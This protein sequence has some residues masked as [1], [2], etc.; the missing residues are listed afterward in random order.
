MANLIATSVWWHEEIFHYITPRI[1]IAPGSYP[2][3]NLRPLSD[4]ALLISCGCLQVRL[5]G[6]TRSASRPQYYCTLEFA[7][8]SL[9]QIRPCHFTL[10]TLIAMYS[11]T[12]LSWAHRGLGIPYFSWLC[13]NCNHKEGVVFSSIGTVT[14]AYMRGE[15]LNETNLRGGKD[16]LAVLNLLP[17]DGSFMLILTM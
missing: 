3:E 15:P 10:W 7:F 17:K 12:T 8:C 13:M 11:S 6:P 1:L 5:C 9:L 16:F 14:L 4:A 2:E